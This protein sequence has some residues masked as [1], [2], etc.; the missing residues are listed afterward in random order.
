MKYLFFFITLVFALPGFGQFS[1]SATPFSYQ[2]DSVV[3]EKRLNTSETLK[4]DS[5]YYKI[6][7]STAGEVMTIRVEPFTDVDSLMAMVFFNEYTDAS[8]QYKQAILTWEAQEKGYELRLRQAERQY[9]R[10]TGENIKVK[11]ESEFDFTELL[12]DW[13]LNGKAIKI[14]AK[15]EI[16]KKPIKILSEQQFTVEIDKERQ[17]FNRLKAGRWEA[18]GGKYKLERPKEKAK[19]RLK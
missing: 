10:F 9:R 11:V 1:I 14:D 18:K 15:L 13:L 17:V 7:Y 5:V 12:G 4:G 2:Q 3:Y 16:D 19:N 8:R 6:T